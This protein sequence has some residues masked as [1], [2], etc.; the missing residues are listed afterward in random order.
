MNTSNILI[1]LILA[2]VLVPA[3]IGTVRHMK[4]EGECCGGPREKAPKK[5]IP[6]KPSSVLKVSIEGMHCDNCKNRVERRLDELDGVVAK[7][8]LARKEAKVYLYSDVSDDVITETITKAGYEVT[9]CVR[10]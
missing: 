4:G 6:G 8:N 10:E 2:V 9:G 3:L 7:V 1:V 5:K